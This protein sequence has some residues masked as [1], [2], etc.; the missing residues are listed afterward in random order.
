VLFAGGL[1]TVAFT[2]FFVVE[3]LKVQVLMTSLVTIAI[4]LN[5]FL[6]ASYDDPFSGDVMVKPTP[7]EYDRKSFHMISN[8]GSGFPD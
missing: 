5:L 6:L 2:Y 1:T 8:P 7:F 4:C 3:N